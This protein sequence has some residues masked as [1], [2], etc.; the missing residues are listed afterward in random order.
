MDFDLTNVISFEIRNPEWPN[1][2]NLPK[3]AQLVRD[4]LHL[5][6][7]LSPLVAAVLDEFPHLRRQTQPRGI[8][9]LG[10]VLTPRHREPHLYICEV[11]ERRFPGKNLAE[12]IRSQ[13][14]WKW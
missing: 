7:F 3:L 5:R 10:G 8:G 4:I 6:S 13:V 14:G 2:K 9:R 11:R 12:V 1:G